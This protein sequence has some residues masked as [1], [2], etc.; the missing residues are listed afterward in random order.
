MRILELRELQPGRRVWLENNGLA[1][2]NMHLRQTTVRWVTSSTVFFSPFLRLPIASYNKELT[3]RCWDERPDL[4]T[5]CE[6]EW[7]MN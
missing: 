4:D 5:A 7:V 3:W 2:K 6:T 1:F